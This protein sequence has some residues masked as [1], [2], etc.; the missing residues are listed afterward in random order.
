MTSSHIPPT[1]P[2][3]RALARASEWLAIGGGAVLVAMATLTVVSVTGRNLLNAPVSG[4]FELV[5]IG[6]AIAVFAFL[7][8]CQMR[9]G[10]IAIDVFARRLP[11]GFVRVLVSLG[12]LMLAAFAA[13]LAWRM[14]IGG[15]EMKATG[16]K[17]IVLGVARWWGFAPMVASSAL[18]SLVALHTA[19]RA[20]KGEEAF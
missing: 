8:H 9:G 13:L 18:L 20:L 6:C 4:D 10:N 2:V 17:T 7:P 14:G 15:L 1:D 19:W 11:P 5:E 3:G 12:A 16:E